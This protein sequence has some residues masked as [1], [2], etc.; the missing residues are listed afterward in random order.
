MRVRALLII[1]VLVGVAGCQAGPSPAAEST[2]A[3]TTTK[4]PTTTPAPLTTPKPDGDT[5]HYRIQFRPEIVDADHR[6]PRIV[7]TS[8]PN[9]VRDPNSAKQIR[10]DPALLTDKATQQRAAA[11]LDCEH[12][13]PLAGRDDPAL[14]LATC[15]NRSEFAV[16][17]RP[18]LLDASMIAGAGYRMGGPVQDHWDVVITLTPAGAKILAAAA[19]NNV[20]VGLFMLFDGQSVEATTLTEKSADTLVYQVPEEADARRLAQVV[21]NR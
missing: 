18:V 7:A 13:D 14:P 3:A 5:P 11:S 16:F 4:K 8:N 12:E 9:P 1:A 10:Q 6:T 19:P 17:L 20:N 15:G 2:I 21:D